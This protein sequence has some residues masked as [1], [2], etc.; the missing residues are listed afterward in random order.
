[1]KV[2][3]AFP[4]AQDYEDYK[5]SGYNAEVCLAGRVKLVCTDDEGHQA[6]SFMKNEEFSRLGLDYIRQHAKLHYCKFTQSWYMTCSEFDWYNA[7]ERYPEKVI[8]V[9]FVCIEEGT[10]R[11]VYRGVDS[12]RYYLREV[13]KREPFAKWY[14]CGTRRRPDDGDE[15]RP[16]LIFQLGDQQEKVRYDDWNGVAAYK[17]Q[18][19]KN[20]RAKG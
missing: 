20:F 6:I 8:P 19:N 17:D 14:V 12:K 13:S 9:E 3:V 11:E 2:E 5:A 10:G 16:N 18:F 15:P 4:S 1:M 7:L